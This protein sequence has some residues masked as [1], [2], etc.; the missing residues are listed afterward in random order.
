MKSFNLC[1]VC[2][3]RG[4]ACWH[5]LCKKIPKSSSCS[6]LAPPLGKAE[7]ISTSVINTFKRGNLLGKGFFVLVALFCFGGE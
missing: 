1:W 6:K 4:R 3:S 7:L 2:D 5:S